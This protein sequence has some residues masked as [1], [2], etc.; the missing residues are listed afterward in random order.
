MIRGSG[1]N[2]VEQSST[3]EALLHFRACAFCDKK[4]WI[5]NFEFWINIP[6]TTTSNMLFL[7]QNYY[8]IPY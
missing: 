1:N 2:K 6:L 3:T 7:I 5:L 4:F 8:K